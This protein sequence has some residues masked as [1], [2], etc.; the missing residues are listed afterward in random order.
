MAAPNKGLS[1][2][3]GVHAAASAISTISQ[4]S[5]AKNCCIL[6]HR[7]ISADAL[8]LF[9]YCSILI[10]KA[11]AVKLLMILSALCLSQAV[12]CAVPKKRGFS[13]CI[14]G[15]QQRLVVGSEFLSPYPF[16]IHTFLSNVQP[17]CKVLHSSNLVPTYPRF[18]N[19]NVYHEKI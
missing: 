16:S 10:Q 8:H 17:I 15:Q 14:C 4:N 5:D 9:W 13:F 19:A 18:H 2:I 11:R 6:R 3:V 12:W 1:C 7:N